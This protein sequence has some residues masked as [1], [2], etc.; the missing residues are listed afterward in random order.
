M[1]HARRFR[2]LTLGGHV[3]ED[4]DARDDPAVTIAHGRGVDRD[5]DG[6]SIGANDA[7]DLV[8]HDLS[9]PHG[10][11]EWPLVRRYPPTVKVKTLPPALGIA[12]RAHRRTPAKQTC[13]F[14]VH[15]DEATARRLRDAD[16]DGRL[17][18]HRDEALVS[19][20]ALGEQSLLLGDAGADIANG[21][22]SLRHGSPEYQK[23]GGGHAHEGLQ[24]EQALM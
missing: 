21:E 13:R 6:A 12:G 4:Q 11:S 5:V 16:G 10:T 15:K 18:E 8:S 20:V 19:D 22:A 7:H 2:D 14:V 24:R 9:V 1:C 23:G 3:P 17:L